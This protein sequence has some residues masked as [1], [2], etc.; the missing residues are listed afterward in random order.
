MLFGCDDSAAPLVPGHV[1]FTRK[2]W[3]TLFWTLKEDKTALFLL[4][5][6]FEQSRLFVTRL[7]L[8]VLGSDGSEEGD[9]AT[10]RERERCAMTFVLLWGA[11]R[12]KF[13]KRN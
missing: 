6:H 11:L 5:R 8:A 12:S 3:V 1:E 7:G 2:D 10:K 4:P 13:L 9:E